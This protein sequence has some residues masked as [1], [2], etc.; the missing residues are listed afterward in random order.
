MTE[1]TWLI[2]SAV[3]VSGF[4]L[5]VNWLVRLAPSV[6]RDEYNLD[7]LE[8]G[9]LFGGR[10]RAKEIAFFLLL[11]DGWIKGD[12]T[13]QFT[14]R[15]DDAP[16]TMSTGPK[17]LLALIAKRESTTLHDLRNLEFPTLGSVE[18]RLVR[19]LLIL[20]EKKFGILSLM[21]RL[22]LG[23]VIL[24]AVKIGGDTY[25]RHEKV[26][27]PIVVAIFAWAAVRFLDRTFTFRTAAGEKL[28]TLMRQEIQDRFQE[29]N[30]VD[31]AGHPYDRL[32]SLHDDV[33]TKGLRSMVGSAAFMTTVNDPNAP[34]PDAAALISY[35]RD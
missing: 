19:K 3:A 16:D 11:R 28:L 8:V 21:T 29:R 4:A 12:P 18:R 22:P 7:E 34:K 6:A 27:A 23:L 31:A 33:L 15:F 13:A 25:I 5:V 30:E 35:K 2:A 1:T 10:E 9:Y 24:M 14:A 17:E 32:W 20:S 26:I